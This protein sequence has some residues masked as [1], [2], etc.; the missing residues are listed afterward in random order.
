MSGNSSNY[1]HDELATLG[2]VGVLQ[3]KYFFRRMTSLENLGVQYTEIL[4]SAPNPI[5]LTFESGTSITFKAEGE[6]NSDIPNVPAAKAGVGIEFSRNGAFVVKAAESYSDSIDNIPSL[7]AQIRKLVA[8]GDWSKEWVVVVGQRRCPAA[9]IVISRSSSSKLEFAVEGDVPA[10]GVVL[11]SADLQLGLAKQTNA[12]FSF[13]NCRNVT[14]LI[15]LARLVKDDFQF[16]GAAAA[17]AA[18]GGPGSGI[19][20]GGLAALSSNE[21]QKSAQT[22]S[23]ATIQVLDDP[24][25]DD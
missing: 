25:D 1:R 22:L 19:E 13:P 4:D 3:D 7:Q 23:F 18:D 9:T 10:G 21:F 6:T 5:D 11:G 20:D 24:E 14:P 2:S 17:G 16:L 8:S 15:Q 12:V